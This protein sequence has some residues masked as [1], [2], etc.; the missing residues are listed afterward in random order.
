MLYHLKKKKWHKNIS[1]IYVVKCTIKFTNNNNNNN[2]KKSYFKSNL[3]QTTIIITL[4]L[5]RSH[6]HQLRNLSLPTRSG[7]RE[8][9]KWRATIKLSEFSVS[10]RPIRSSRSSDSCPSPSDPISIASPRIR[11]WRYTHSVFSAHTRYIYYF[12]IYMFLICLIAD[13]LFIFCPFCFSMNIAVFVQKYSS[14]VELHS[15]NYF[16]WEHFLACL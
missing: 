12:F 2:K 5:Q 9:G 3:V 7:T 4:R 6:P 15:V 10:E 8:V 16:F 13:C 1:K 14:N 11:R